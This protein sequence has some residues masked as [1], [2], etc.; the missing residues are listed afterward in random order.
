MFDLFITLLAL[1]GIIAGVIYMGLKS[2]G[3]CPHLETRCTHGDETWHRMK[4]YTFRFWKPE[5]IRR[6]I[7]KQ[8]GAALSRVAICTA[9]GEDLHEWE[10]PW[11]YNEGTV[12]S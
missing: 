12:A 9:T 4:V 10:G 3:P 1:F 8:C 2:Q 11:P 5:E 7:C 6:Q